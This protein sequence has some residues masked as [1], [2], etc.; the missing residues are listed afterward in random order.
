MLQDHFD[1]P[2]RLCVAGQGVLQRK[3]EFRGL[4]A[5]LIREF[6]SVKPVGPV[7]ST[8]IL[9]TSGTRR[10]TIG[11]RYVPSHIEI[12]KPAENVARH[13]FPRSRRKWAGPCSLASRIQSEK[14]GSGPALVGLRK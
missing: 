14:R 13:E 4:G 3:T 5:P 6:G 2:D 11:G 8:T 1:L 9:T 12:G 10:P 7:P